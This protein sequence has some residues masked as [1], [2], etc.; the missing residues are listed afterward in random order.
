MEMGLDQPSISGLSEHL[1]M[2]PSNRRG[3][4]SGP[5]LES[6]IDET[7]YLVAQYRVHEPESLVTWFMGREFGASLA[8]CG[9]DADACRPAALAEVDYRVAGLEARCSGI[10]GRRLQRAS[11]GDG[12]Q[13]RSG[14]DADAQ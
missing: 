3:A 1:G 5:G 2:D 10:W 4:T 8:G 11:C 12:T 14:R 7:A 9:L 6:L 13:P